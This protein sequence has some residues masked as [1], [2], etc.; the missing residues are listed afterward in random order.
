[1]TRGPTVEIAHEALLTSWTRLNRWIATS[2]DGLRLYH[3]LADDAAAWADGG[4][5]PSFL[6]RGSRLE[7]LAAWSDTADVAL[8]GVE[9]AFLDES[10]RQAD[11]QDR[12]EADRQA[13]E[14]Q[15]QRRSVRRL[16]AAVAFLAGGVLIAGSLGFVTLDRGRQAELQ[17]RI[18]SAREVAAAANASL[19]VDSQRS[20]LLALEA[21]ETTRREG[22]A[23]LPEAEEALHAA[24]QADRLL[25]TVPGYH[26]RFNADGSRLLVDGIYTPALEAGEVGVKEAVVYDAATGDRVAGTTLEAQEPTRVVFGPDERWFVHQSVERGL[27]VVTVADGAVQWSQ[28]DVCCNDTWMDPLG[29]SMATLGSDGLTLV[30]DPS[31]GAEV[32]VLEL[33]GPVAFA[34]DG[35]HSAAFTSAPLP[36]DDVSIVGYIG[37]LRAPGGGDLVRVRG[38]DR[39]VIEAAWSPDGS[40]L[41]AVSPGEGTIWDADTG[42]LRVAF[43]PPDSAFASIAFD[44]ASSRV[45][46]GMTDGTAIVWQLSGHQAAPVLHLAGHGMQVGSVAFHP[47][48]DR[49]VTGGADGHAK[50]WD[51][52]LEGGHESLTVK[53]SH[54]IA[55]SPDGHLLASGGRGEAT[56][57]DARSGGA[58]AVLP[59]PGGDVVS[60]DFSGDGSM[61]A[62]ALEQD[63][64]SVWA[65]ATWTRLAAIPAAEVG[66]VAFGPTG[67]TLAVSGATAVRL[68]D[69]ATGTDVGGTNTAVRPAVRVLRR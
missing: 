61:L 47:S 52:T 2:R 36:E 23:V 16:R 19:Q 62:V 5:D 57:H 44:A 14:T 66:P 67:S 29:R 41:A 15:L 34:P 54:A 37:R 69:G 46:T 45:A 8:S 55:W 21:A 58:V 17:A 3:R 11:E 65:T 28:P 33:R 40:M 31:T 64:V 13:R 43:F 59:A 27:A 1:M 35:V 9:G 53:G 32:N 18:A 50:V 48:G 30:F 49:L 56:V 24:I 7:Q 60:L 12:A 68:V 22:G 39:N 26:A 20:L 38:H 42:E 25:L 10:R 4:R 63:S 6:L 51:I